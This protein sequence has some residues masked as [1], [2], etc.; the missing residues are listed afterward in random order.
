MVSSHNLIEMLSGFLSIKTINL[1]LWQDKHMALIGIVWDINS[2][3][4]NCVPH[5]D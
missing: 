5:L 3:S 4:G 1:W 2:S